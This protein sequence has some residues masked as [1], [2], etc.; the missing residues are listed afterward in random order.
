MLRPLRKRL[1]QQM[2][3]AAATMAPRLPDGAL[4]AAERVIGSSGRHLPILGRMVEENLR[5][6]GL[7][8]PRVLSAYFAQVGRHLSNALRIIA[9]V[10]NPAASRRLAEQE[11]HAE[12]SALD[13]A[14]LLRSSG[15]LVIAAPHVC[16]YPLTMVRLNQIVPV[17]D[18]QRWSKD[19]RNQAIKDQ[20]ARGAGLEVIREPPMMTDPTRRAMACV[21]TVRGGRALVLT[22]DLAQKSDRGVPV[23]LL[24]RR[25][26]LPSG[27]ASIA[28]LAGVPFVPMFGRLVGHTHHIYATEPLQIRTLKR[29]EGGRA[30]ALREVMQAWADQFEA[31]VRAQPEL[32][33]F[34]GDRSWTRAFHGD[35]RYTQPLVDDQ[36]QMPLAPGEVRP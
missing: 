16:N 24:G 29:S 21:E 20:W 9:N 15:G 12:S 6:A 23:R 26:Y 3:Y 22:P 28:M 14:S 35:P 36:A 33:F 30:A 7:Y 4:R 19:A 1:A 32:W 8:H 11:I 18:Y 27:P 17:C 13:L 2:S 31:F 5:S 25:V 34:W 10:S